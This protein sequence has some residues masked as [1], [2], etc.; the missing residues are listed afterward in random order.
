MNKQL[1]D[2]LAKF[3]EARLKIYDAATPVQYRGRYTH[4]EVDKT[5]FAANGVIFGDWL[6]WG[7]TNGTMGLTSPNGFGRVIGTLLERRG[8]V[9]GRCQRTEN[10]KKKT[11]YGWFGVH[12]DGSPTPGG[13][14]VEDVDPTIPPE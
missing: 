7:K 5:L 9:Y 1:Y 10:G 11:I 4:T 6:D 13:I 12:C 3:L 2:H 14:R 8:A